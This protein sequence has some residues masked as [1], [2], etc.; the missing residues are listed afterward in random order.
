M[1]RGPETCDLKIYP[2]KSNP[3]RYEVLTKGAKG[4]FKVIENSDQAKNEVIEEL[5]ETIQVVL[6][7]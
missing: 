2:K 1:F 3:I 6:A 5:K 4:K 7:N